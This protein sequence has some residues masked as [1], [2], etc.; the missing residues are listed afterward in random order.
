MANVLVAQA[1]LFLLSSSG[2]DSELAFDVGASSS[3]NPP[4]LRSRED[5]SKQDMG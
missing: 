5:T 1:V 3:E 4:L 2:C